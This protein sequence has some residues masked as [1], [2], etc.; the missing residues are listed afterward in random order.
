MAKKKAIPY[1]SIR[2]SKKAKTIKKSI[3]R[4]KK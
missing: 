2:K 1:G 4:K 3:K